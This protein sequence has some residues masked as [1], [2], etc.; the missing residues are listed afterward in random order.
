MIKVAQVYPQTL[1]AELGLLTAL[2]VGCTLLAS[3]TPP[4]ARERVLLTASPRC[5]IVRHSKER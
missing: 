3:L 5:G 1:A 4:P 2:G